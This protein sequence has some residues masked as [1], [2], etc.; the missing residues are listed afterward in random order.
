[1]TSNDSSLASSSDFEVSEIEEYE[2]EVEG[3]PNSR[4]QATD[5][6]ETKRSIFRRAAGRYRMASAI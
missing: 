6:D 5:V 4:D 1:M 3:S 2:S